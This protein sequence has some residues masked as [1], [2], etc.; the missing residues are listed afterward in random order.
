MV[1][2]EILH[3][4]MIWNEKFSEPKKVKFLLGKIWNEKFLGKIREM[5]HGN[6]FYIREIKHSGLLEGGERGEAQA[7][8]LTQA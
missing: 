2:F 4:E 1:L 8:A 7:Q 5:C 3:F 6:I